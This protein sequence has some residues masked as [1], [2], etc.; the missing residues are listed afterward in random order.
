[1]RYRWIRATNLG[2]ALLAAVVLTVL[3]MPVAMAQTVMEG[4]SSPLRAFWEQQGNWSDQTTKKVLRATQQ[5]GSWEVLVDLEKNGEWDRQGILEEVY[6]R[7]LEPSPALDEGLKKALDSFV[8][9]ILIGAVQSSKGNRLYVVGAVLEQDP[10]LQDSEG[11]A[12]KS[13][14]PLYVA[15]NYQNVRQFAL[16]YEQSV[17]SKEPSGF[18]HRVPAP[19]E[20]F[21]KLLS[22]GAQCLNQQTRAYAYCDSSYSSCLSAADSFYSACNIAC[23]GNGACQAGCFS[24]WVYQRGSCSISY[25]DCRVNAG[26]AYDLCILSCPDE[27]GGGVGCKAANHTATARLSLD[28]STSFGEKLASS[29]IDFALSRSEKRGKESFVLDEWA[30]V[31]DGQVRVSS[32]PAFASAAIDQ[33]AVPALGSFLMIQE[34]IHEMNSRYVPKPEVRI[35]EKALASSERGTREIVAARLEI[36]PAGVVDRVEIVYTS[37]PLDAGRLEKLIS[38]RVS[39]TFTTGKGHRTAVYVVF[40]LTDHLEILHTY[41]VLPKCCCGGVRCN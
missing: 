34:P 9:N 11:G 18:S 8:A 2:P 16:R 30:V 7:R 37:E 3:L 29:P 24:V 28:D 5:L 20:G 23:L 19:P 31:Q 41:T 4:K 12:L 39:L 13:F 10:R 21:E 14:L 33:H 17:G 6:R 22:C 32:S 35:S 38:Q 27:D 40:R 26:R 36:A 25:G 15:E 1:M